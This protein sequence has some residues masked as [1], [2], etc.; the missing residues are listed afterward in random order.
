M[1]SVSAIRQQFPW[2]QLIENEQNAGFARGNNQAF[3][4]SSGRYVL[5]LN[6]DT[7][8]KPRA[9][10]TLLQ[11]M[12][13]HPRCGGCGARLLN[14]DGTLQPS[15]QPML[16]PWREFWRLTFLDQLGAALPITW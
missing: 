4:A 3:A 1:S 14:S 12:E 16:T 15:C 8:V 13:D 11:F 5:L 10:L 6:S 2:A 9:M 7:V